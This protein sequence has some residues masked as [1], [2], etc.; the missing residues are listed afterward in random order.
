MSTNSSSSVFDLAAHRNKAALL[1]RS[2]VLTA[3]FFF[4]LNK[5]SMDS[6]AALG[7]SYLLEWLLPLAIKPFHAHLKAMIK[8]P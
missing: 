2:D 1:D 8:A 3:A 4:K 7:P 5:S 6:M